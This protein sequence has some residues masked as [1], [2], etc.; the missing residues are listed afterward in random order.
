MIIKNIVNF[1][2]NIGLKVVVIGDKIDNKNIIFFRNLKRERVLSLLKKTKFTII[3]N[4]NFYSLFCID[5]ISCDVQIFFDKRIKPNIFF[6]NKPLC[7]PIDFENLEHTEN[8]IRY[9]LI[10]YKFEKCSVKNSYYSQIKKINIAVKKI[11][12]T[13]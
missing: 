12:D 9:N 1:L 4:E 2:T 10:N 11:S 13:L 6:F 8:K 7:I 5:A 3:S